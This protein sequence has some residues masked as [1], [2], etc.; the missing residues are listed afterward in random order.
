MEIHDWEDGPQP[1]NLVGTFTVYIPAL[2]LSLHKTKA[3]RTKKGGIFIAFP[4]F[5]KEDNIGQKTWH[6]YISFS[7]QRAK[8]FQKACLEAIEPFLGPKQASMI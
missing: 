6:P 2:G 7:E 4:S 8:E 1:G 5:C 3:V